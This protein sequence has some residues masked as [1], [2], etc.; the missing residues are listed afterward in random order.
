MQG[1]AN[2]GGLPAW[3]VR[4]GAVVLATILAFSAM[5]DQREYSAAQDLPTQPPSPVAVEQ[6]PEAQPPAAQPQAAPG[7]A[8]LW[9]RR[10][11]LSRRRR[12]EQ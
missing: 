2:A 10:I 6:T 4:G 5:V 1:A 8:E 3:A 12:G 11:P 7:S 9:Q